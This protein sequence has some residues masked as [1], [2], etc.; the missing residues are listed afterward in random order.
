[1]YTYIYRESERNVYMFDSYI[2]SLPLLPQSVPAL[3]SPPWP[4][5]I[6][7]SIYIYR[8]KEREK[9]IYIRFV[10]Y[11]VTSAGSV[12]TS[13][14]LPPLIYI[15]IYIYT[16]VHIFIN[17]YDIDV[18]ICLHIYIESDRER[19]TYAHLCRLR[20]YQRRALLLDLLLAQLLHRTPLNPPDP[21]SETRDTR[22]EWSDMMRSWSFHWVYTTLILS[23]VHLVSME[24]F[25]LEPSPRR[26]LGLTRGFSSSGLKVLCSY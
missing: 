14:A 11:M 3:R 13:V 12:S 1:M 23:R 4:F 20:Q 24:Q 18:H 22:F 2:I 17:I 21:G 9:C 15:Y 26:Q 10:Y 5:H 19:C 16:H 25:N 7:L 8:E 6:Y